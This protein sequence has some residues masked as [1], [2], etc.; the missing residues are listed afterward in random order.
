M[1]NQG[2]QPYCLQEAWS[3]C[4]FRQK[5]EPNITPSS[6]QCC[7]CFT[8]GKGVWSLVCFLVQTTNGKAASQN[9]AHRQM[10]EYFTNSRIQAGDLRCCKITSPF[11]SHFL[12]VQSN[13]GFDGKELCSKSTA[14]V[15]L[16]G[17]GCSQYKH[18]KEEGSA[19]IKPS[20]P[21]NPSDIAVV[22]PSPQR[23]PQAAQD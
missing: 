20:S 18:G 9:E 21:R 14:G 2:S 1:R 17:D 6:Q 15:Q 8:G 3:L 5:R 13:L 11:L 22:L 23:P 12:D 19:E 4:P 7:S 16:C 10:N